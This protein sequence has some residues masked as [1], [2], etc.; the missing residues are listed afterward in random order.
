MSGLMGWASRTAYARIGGS[1]VAV[2]NAAPQGARRLLA[3]AAI[4]LALVLPAS[5]DGLEGSWRLVQRT[6]SDGRVD[7]PPQVVG[8]VTFTQGLRQVSLFW[9]GPDGQ[10]ASL[11][12]V[13]RAALVGSTY[14]ETQL[15]MALDLG[16]G[17]PVVY[18][19]GGETR[20]APVSQ[21]PAGPAYKMPFD[22]LD[23]VHDGN[24][25]TAALNGQFVDRW[26]KVV[27]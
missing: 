13:S 27:P 20:T 26:E 22:A 23:V 1:A 5:A 21:G 16:G 3:G 8:L 4:A 7:T 19:K 9:P 14:T 10:P 12:I 15:A 18:G 6:W 2:C 25:F 17:T 11:S 24:R